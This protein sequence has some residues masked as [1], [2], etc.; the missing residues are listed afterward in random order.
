MLAGFPPFRRGSTADTLSAILNEEPQELGGAVPPALERVVHHCLEKKPENRFQNAR[1]LAFGLESPLPAGAAR[2]RLRCLVVASRTEGRHGACGL[3]ACSVLQSSPCS[4][5]S[6]PTRTPRG[7]DYR[8]RPVPPGNRL[9]RAGGV[10]RD[11]A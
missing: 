3:P 11:L 2:R 5:M 4:G 6:P 1:D 10:S 8:H 7:A 9:R